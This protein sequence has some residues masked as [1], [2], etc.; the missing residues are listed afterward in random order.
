[1][2]ALY[3][4]PLR[5]LLFILGLAVSFLPRRAELWLAPRLGRFVLWTGAF[6]TKVAAENL[7]RC[8]PE[9]S[10]AER[11]RLLVANFEHYGALFFEYL[12]LFSPLKGHYR[13]YMKEHLVLEGYEHWKR[14]HDK[15][16]GV[17]F[18]A[19]HLGF[20]EMLG[21]A[22]GLN[23]MD[24]TAVTTVL[25]PR[26]LH[27]KVTASRLSTG[28]RAAYHPGSLPTVLRALKKGESVAFMNDQYAG[29]P[30]GMPVTFFGVK[31]ATLA[32]VGPIS[33]RTGAALIPSHTYRD[34]GGRSHVV[35]EPELELGAAADNAEE[36]TQIFAAKVEQW[37]RRHPEQWLWIH[38][39]FKNV[40]WP[41]ERAGAAV[42]TGRPG[43]A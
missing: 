14:A 20:W 39:R 13:A 1:M 38:R 5:A 17:I 43:A 10:E 32:A 22:G 3:S 7:R 42:R 41:E 25:K 30:M 36:A 23:D 21:A 6:K 18:V 33:K 31:V 11:Q 34:K 24:L 27:D 4:A 2:A 16:K 29:P 12:H 37:V 15:G 40:T 9:L 8:F 26:W 35:L 19:C 28:V